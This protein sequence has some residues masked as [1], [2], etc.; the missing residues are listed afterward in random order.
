[1]DRVRFALNPYREDP[2][3]AALV[4]PPAGDTLAFHRPLPG[5]RETPLLALPALAAALGLSA[6]WVKDEGQRFGL[7]ASWAIHRWMREEKQ[8]RRKVGAGLSDL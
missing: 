3:P 6:L 5:Y 8:D 1:M 7:G 4:P 2:L